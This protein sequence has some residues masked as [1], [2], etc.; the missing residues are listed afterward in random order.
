MKTQSSFHWPRLFQCV[1]NISLKG[2]R[3]AICTA[4]VTLSSL[5]VRA[6]FPWFS[7]Y[8]NPTNSYRI[9]AF[10]DWDT[11]LFGA[12]I[13]PDTDCFGVQSPNYRVDGHMVLA[14]DGTGNCVVIEAT[15]SYSGSLG[16]TYPVSFQFSGWWCNPA[17]APT[18]DTRH[19]W[20]N[21]FLNIVSDLVSVSAST[22]ATPIRPSIAL[23]GSTV[24]ISWPADT[25]NNYRVMWSPKLTESNIWYSLG[26]TTAGN[27]TTNTAYDSA[28]NSSRF[29][30]VINVQ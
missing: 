2:L 23:A 28:T 15:G 5:S 9:Y 13:Y 30:R 10:T 24:A 27:G 7:G 29:Y 1:D 8:V 4:V 20:D 26:T 19:D 18:S 17:S 6:A 11:P 22:N 14:A 3:I 25:N 21:N 16:A 12:G